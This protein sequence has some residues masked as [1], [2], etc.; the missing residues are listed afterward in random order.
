MKT[1]TMAGVVVLAVLVGACD[2]SESPPDVNAACSNVFTYCPTGYT[3]SPYFSDAAGC[4]QM[5]DCVIGFYTA[6]CRSRME[7]AA[8]CLAGLTDGYRCAICDGMFAELQ[9]LCPEPMP[10]LP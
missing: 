6:N 2:A 8:R 9:P 5:F 10:C 1:A 4:E 3:W 7:E